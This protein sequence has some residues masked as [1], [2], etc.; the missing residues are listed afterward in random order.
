MADYRYA[1]GEVFVVDTTDFYADGQYFQSEE[2]AG[3]VTV[4]VMMHHYQQ[5]TG[6]A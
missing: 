3:G 4:P 1:D 5:Q 6:A 2:A